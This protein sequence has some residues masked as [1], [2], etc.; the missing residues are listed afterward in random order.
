MK[1][2]IYGRRAVVETLRAGRRK[3]HRLKQ[4]QGL[5]GGQDAL[6]LAAA[7]KI[8]I[9]QVRRNELDGLGEN[10]QGLA[11]QVDEYPYSHLG[12]LLHKAKTSG[13]PPF[14]LLLDVL[15]DPQNL[16]TLLRSAEAVGVHGVLL[17]A[18]RAAGITPA[19]VNAS[20]GAC[21][22]LL[23][24]QHNL[25]QAIAELKRENVWVIGL[26]GGH[27]AQPLGRLRLD[28]AL[29]LVVGSE[30]EGLRRLVR[31][32]CDA[33]LS[34]PMRG[35]IESLNAAVAGSVALYMAWQ[36]RNFS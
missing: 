20:A 12:E 9:E 11:L 27:G 35:K 18:R 13:E 24:A 28:G 8:P 10:H 26:E 34:L 30:G 22:H 3:A 7:R 17:P 14:F 23:V 2:W 29:A 16:G 32:S 36:A 21:E 1:E 4:A 25:A 33:L 19:V 31:E 6:K 5:Q 15:Q